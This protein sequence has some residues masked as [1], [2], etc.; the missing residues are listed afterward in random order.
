MR[1]FWFILI[2]TLLI[3]LPAIAEYNV[4]DSPSLHI[5]GH[6]ESSY[7]TWNAIGT[8]PLD[9]INGY[10][11]AE[12]SHISGEND[13][14]SDNIRARLEG[15]YHFG[16]LGIRG[17]ARYGQSH[18]MGSDNMYHGGAYLHI[19]IIDQP[20]IRF[21]AGIGAWMKYESFLEEYD[22]DDTSEAG[23]HAHAELQ[24]KN[25][26]LLAECLPNHTLDDYTVRIIPIWEMPLFKVLFVEQVSLEIS[27]QIAYKSATHHI[28][29]EPWQW[30]WKHALKFGF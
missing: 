9:F 18:S 8:M 29:I 17:Y 3:V 21:T 25:I 13:F 7:L 10:A 6:G 16:A 27:G 24:L 14:T 28:E 23:P 12:W 20:T 4:G 2:I 5:A 19:D 1:I 15:G 30:H 26:S 11:G 22:V